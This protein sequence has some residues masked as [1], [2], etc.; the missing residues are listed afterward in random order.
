MEIKKNTSKFNTGRTK[1]KQLTHII[2]H[3]YEMTEGSH[4]SLQIPCVK[5][6]GM[7]LSYIFNLYL[8]LLIQIL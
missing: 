6:C 8:R 3:F 5:N 7:N 1:I 2:S 4:P